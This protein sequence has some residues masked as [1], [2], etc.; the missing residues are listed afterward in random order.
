MQNRI[1][2]VRISTAA[3]CN[4]RCSFCQTGGDYGSTAANIIPIKDERNGTL[5]VTA[6]QFWDAGVRHFSL[7][8]GEPLTN[9]RVTF[10]LSSALRQKLDAWKAE[11]GGD[12]CYLRLNTNGVFVKKYIDQVVKYY[13][14]VKISLH[15][16][17]SD[18]Y[19]S[20]TGSRTPAI[21][22]EATLQGIALLN[23]RGTKVRVQTVATPENVHELWQLIEL[24]QRYENITD[25]KVFDISEYSELWRNHGDGSEF[26]N[27]N[28]VSLDSF[29]KEVR[30]RGGN[31]LYIA[32]SIGGYG[33]PMPIYQ[34]GSL[35][36]RLR[37]SSRGAFYSDSCKNCTAWKT[38]GDGHCNAEVGPNGVIKVCRPSEGLTFRPG[39]EKKVIAFFQNVHFD[40]RSDL[41]ERWTRRGSR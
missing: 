28:Y 25:F 7:T 24:C 4:H 30:T 16:L 6:F 32:Q 8:G 36:I 23:E 12:D 5:I 9:P 10:E 22:L 3:G 17:K 21:D 20:I 2:S 40:P 26:F 38:C 34:L 14:L 11:S 41:H 27:Q 29:E 19:A 13:D 18:V 33:N 31:L 39:E 1:P 37:H 35:R 15:S